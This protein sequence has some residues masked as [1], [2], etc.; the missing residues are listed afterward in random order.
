MQRRTLA[1]RKALAVTPGLVASTVF[2][3]MIGLVLPGWLALPLFV[4]GPLVLL[5]LVFGGLEGRAVRVLRGGRAVTPDEAAAVAPAVELLHDLGVLP[6]DCRLYVIPGS[7]GWDTWGSG[8]RSILMTEDLLWATS[9]GAL[10]DRAVAAFLA[11]SAGR[12][13]HGLTRSDPAIEFWSLPWTVI[14]G[15]LDTML[16]S[17]VTQPLVAFSWHARFIV[18]SVAVAQTALSGHYPMAVTIAAIVLVSY[19]AP[20]WRRRWC[21]ISERLADQYVRAT[22][23]GSDLG[24]ALTLLSRTP[25]TLRRVQRLTHDPTVS[26]RHRWMGKP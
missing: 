11:H 13:R 23:L 24:R 7:T 25:E 3:W 21:A 9:R 12:V 20:W 17:T 8:R 22:G 15:V 16:S 4:V 5:I 1:R 6:P 2:T 19:L 26:T 18:G 14:R 10:D